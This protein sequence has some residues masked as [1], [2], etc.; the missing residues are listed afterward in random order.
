MSDYLY[1]EM[2]NNRLYN[3]LLNTNE[4][5]DDWNNFKKRDWILSDWRM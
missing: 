4:N 2:R 3:C 5:S 1:D